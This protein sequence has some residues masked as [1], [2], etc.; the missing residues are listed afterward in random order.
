MHPLSL[1][2]GRHPITTFPHM[3]AS[4]VGSA[5]A[6]IA[7]IDGRL[8][9]RQPI[10]APVRSLLLWTKPLPSTAKSRT[11]ASAEPGIRRVPVEGNST[12]EHGMKR[13]VVLGL[14]F[15][16]VACTPQSPPPT[17]TTPP[18]EVAAAPPPPPAPSLP[19]MLASL[20]GRYAGMMTVG[21][22]GT[23]SQGTTYPIC[24]TRPIN[25]TIRNGYATIWYQDWKHHTLHY[26]GRVDSAGTINL[27]H[28]NGDGSRS[29]FSLKISDAGWYGEMQ[30]GNCWYN[31]AM[32]RT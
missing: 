6:F 8:A 31:V 20:N 10:P 14:F 5:K 3:R 13:L 28:L 26:R 22:S 4:A 1:K 15:V 17:A 23:E 2:Y 21:V 27:S 25:M 9:G 29:D 18:P 32:N 30:R 7:R 12:L 24:S 11:M 16:A 19:A